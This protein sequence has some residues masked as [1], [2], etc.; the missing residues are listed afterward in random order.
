MHYPNINIPF[1]IYTDSLDYQMGA[2]IMQ[3]GHPVAY[4]S[5]KLN[6]AQHNYSTIKKELLAIVHCLVEHCT[7]LWGA[8]LTVYTDH[9]NLTFRTLNTQ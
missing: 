5:R 8:R 4:W 3:N 7:M 9:K 2:V 1:K 6:E